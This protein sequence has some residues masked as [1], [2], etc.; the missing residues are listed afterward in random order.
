MAKRKML[1]RPIMSGK[2]SELVSLSIG[3]T[4]APSVR[5]ASP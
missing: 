3:C 1:F 2:K 4:S 5:L